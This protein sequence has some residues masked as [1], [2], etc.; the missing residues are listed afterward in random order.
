MGVGVG[1]G[2]GVGDGVGVAVTDGVGVAAVGVE[3]TA[4]YVAIAAPPTTIAPTMPPMR[5]V[6]LLGDF[7][8]ILT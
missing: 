6:R 2:V 3:V 1:V 7:T 4:A 5:S 8:E